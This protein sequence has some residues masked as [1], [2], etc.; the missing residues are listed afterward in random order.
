MGDQK[1][2]ACVANPDYPGVYVEI[3]AL[4]GQSLDTRRSFWLRD[5]EL[6]PCDP[7]APGKA[8][9]PPWEGE[10][11]ATPR[12]NFYGRMEGAANPPKGIQVRRE[13]YAP[14]GSVKAWWRYTDP[15]AA[16]AAHVEPNVW[17]R[18]DFP[19]LRLYP[20]PIRHMAGLPDGSILAIGEGYARSVRF[21]PRTN[22]RT[23]LGQTMSTYSVVPF[24][25]KVYL[26]G[27]P[28]SLVWVYD[29]ARPWTAGQAGDG[30]PADDAAISTTNNKSNAST[31]DT[32]PAHVAKLKDFTDVHMPWASAVGADGRVYFGGKVVRIGNGGG[33]GWWD[34]RKQEAGGF[35]EPFERDTI[36]WMCAAD[37][38]RYIVCSTKPVA[39]RNDPDSKPRRGRIFVYDT[40]KREI[41]H[42]VDDERLEHFP[43]FI[44]E[45]M[46]GLVMGYAPRKQEADGG[47]LYGFDA[48]AGKVLWTKPVP[49]APQTAFSFMRRGR[50]EFD[51]GPDGFVWTHMGDTLVRIDP[52]TA[53]VHPVGKMPQDPLLF[54]DGDMY[55]AGAEQ[56][57]RITGLPKV[58]T[59]K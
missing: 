16:Q 22:E 31:R 30:P 23:P 46:P 49:V 38:G 6:T 45:A 44:T 56:F 50:Y 13:P 27:Y 28:G 14:D 2:I 53:E 54:L 4:K 41:V 11:R 59:V 10:K 18:I 19:R 3:T 36:H 29:P 8:P 40:T 42:T 5:G 9:I 34:T 32:N 48:A 33:L 20:V 26:C 51:R 47:L 52:R 57:R 24:E 35:Y 55:V 21:D 15:A 7:V 12:R 43:G 17:Q 39:G 37:A 1:T 58:K 25:Q